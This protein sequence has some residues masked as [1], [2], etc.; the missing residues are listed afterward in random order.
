[1]AQLFPKWTNSIPKW[2]LMVGPFLLIGNIAF[3]GYYFS[4]QY[5]DVG[6][7]PEQP[8]PYSHRLHAGE[9]GIDCRYCH[10]SVEQSPVSNI[11]PTQTCMNC[12]RLVM[13]DSK[14]LALIRNSS[15]TGQ[16]IHWVRVHN[17]PDYAFFNHAAHV[18]VG[19]GCINCHGPI[20]EMEEVWQAEPLSMSWCLDCHRNPVPSLRPPEEVTNMQWQPTAEWLAEA[21]TMHVE[22]PQDCSGCHR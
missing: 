21:E 10:V 14:K 11:P 19:V 17:L 16:P 9:L 2:L 20:H 15:E 3:V 7:M 5:T 8:V 18:N 12:H 13:K 6:Y 22:P 4:P 1:M